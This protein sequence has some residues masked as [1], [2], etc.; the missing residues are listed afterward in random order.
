M[1]TISIIDIIPDFDEE[2][3]LG[4]SDKPWKDKR[5]SKPKRNKRY[6]SDEWEEQNQARKRYIKEWEEDLRYAQELANEG[7]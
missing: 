3:E 6:S 2:E 4:L 5:K 7:M 1:N